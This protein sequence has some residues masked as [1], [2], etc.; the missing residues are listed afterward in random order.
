MLLALAAG[1]PARVGGVEGG[2]CAMYGLCR[3]PG[4]DAFTPR[5]VNCANAPGAVTPPVPAFNLTACPEFQAAACCS[6]EQVRLRA[7][8]G[9]V[10]L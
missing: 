6:E 8:R 1:A 7:P 9:G 10:L 3:A 5:S 4:G 2:S